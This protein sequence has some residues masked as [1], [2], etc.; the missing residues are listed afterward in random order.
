MP[1]LTLLNEVES[2]QLAT[3][4]KKLDLSGSNVVAHGRYVN[5]QMAEVV[6][7]RDLFRE[8]LRPADRLRIPTLAA[9]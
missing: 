3:T 7:A 4:R 2:W 8:I 1:T 6:R 5:F 9:A